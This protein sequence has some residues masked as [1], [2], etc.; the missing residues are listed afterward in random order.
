MENKVALHI[1]VF[2]DSYLYMREAR[3][4]G[5][6]I[7]ATHPMDIVDKYYYH[8]VKDMID[9]FYIIDYM[10]TDAL[11]QLASD[12]GAEM[13]VTHP[14]TNDASMAMAVVNTRMGFNGIGETAAKYCASKEAWQE[15]L[16]EQNLPG[17]KWS[18]R[19]DE[20]TELDSLTYPC[21]VK[22][23]YGA[24][25]NG[26]KKIDSAEEL[27][28]FMRERDRSN[29][30]NLNKKYD[31][32]LVQEY[33]HADYFSG[34]NCYV[35]NGVIKP[36]THYAR[37][38][39][40][41]LEQERLPY[42]YYEEGLFP[43]D[44]KFLTQ[45]VLD[46]LQ[47]LASVLEIEN[48]ALRTEFFYDE[49]LKVINVIETN[50]RPGS[51]HTATSFHEIYGYNVTQELVKLNSPDLKADF[52]RKHNTQFKYSLGKQFKFSPGKIKSI[53]WPELTD[54]I[55]H[56]SSTLKPGDVIPENWNAS[57]GHQNGQLILLGESVDDIYQQL[58]KFTRSIR[59]TY[60]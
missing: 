19:Y 10:D 7:V 18:H 6:K 48:G 16:I 49:N 43:S 52:T 57:V 39:K 20:L 60:E 35:Q 56:F 41:K 12:C 4:L 55:H 27:E 8:T 1:G 44:S 58:D 47:N 34:V 29:G 37:D 40:S 54:C 14:C 17:P 23:N 5:Y 13:T 53:E 36:Y 28:T 9:E 30:W 22:P 21:I 38:Q 33:T 46:I 24:G 2:D 59:I 31:Y 45:E 15:L 11:V 32:Y 42:F 26:I 25:S 3:A 51:S 50:L